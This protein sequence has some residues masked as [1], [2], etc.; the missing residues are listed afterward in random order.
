MAARLAAFFKITLVVFL[1]A[2]EGLRRFNQSNDALWLEA[3]FS[4]KLCDLGLSLRF[5][6]RRVEEDGRSVLRAPVRTLA[7]EGG[8]VVQGEER[9][10]EL[11]VGDPGRVE[12][13]FNNFCVA[14]LVGAD[15]L[16]AGSGQRAA[17]IAYSGC[18]N[19]GDGGKGSF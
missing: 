12:V 14:G 19:A 7:V 15:V 8:G 18:G 6:F 10:E 17:L 2:P 13:Q 9:V 3:A 1:G 11:L 4:G 16:V 5:L